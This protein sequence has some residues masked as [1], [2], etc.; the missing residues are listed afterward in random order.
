MVGSSRV[1]CSAP[2]PYGRA[3][4]HAPIQSVNELAMHGYEPAA[5]GSLVG[6]TSTLPLALLAG[7]IVGIGLTLLVAVLARVP[8]TSP[9]SS[10][11]RSR[12][13]R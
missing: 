4:A 6:V 10:R 9:M 1:R 5:T 11:V 3:V 2:D 12:L 13:T 8:L 7:A